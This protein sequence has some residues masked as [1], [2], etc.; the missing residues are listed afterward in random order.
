MSSP[1]QQARDSPLCFAKIGEQVGGFPFSLRTV[2]RQELADSSSGMTASHECRKG[3][4]QVPQAVALKSG[5]C[6][7]PSAQLW[8][9]DHAASKEP[10][11]KISTDT[12]A[13]VI[14]RVRRPRRQTG[15][16]QKILSDSPTSWMYSQC[17]ANSE[18]SRKS[19]GLGF[20]CSA[21]L[22]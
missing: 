5:I 7:K 10:C 1:V 22:S 11:S 6:E 16:I 9:N 14:S 20:S 19:K 8:D 21:F 17:G 13:R 2:R 18:R 4:C 3:T 15:F 12:T